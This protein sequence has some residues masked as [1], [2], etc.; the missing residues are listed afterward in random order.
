MVEL[1]PG[2]HKWLEI[3]EAE[4]K[5]ANKNENPISTSPG[6]N[7]SQ[8]Q[9][10]SESKQSSIYALSTEFNWLM[11]FQIRKNYIA[12]LVDPSWGS[13]ASKNTSGISILV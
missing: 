1:F 3:K 13:E 2:I 9:N 6:V 7:S 4:D 11:V 5:M 12:I 8:K 10:Q